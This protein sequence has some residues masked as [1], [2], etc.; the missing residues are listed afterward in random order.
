MLVWVRACGLVASLMCL[1]RV[2]GV[3]LGVLGEK[4][5]H[6]ILAQKQLLDYTHNLYDIDYTTNPT[7]LTH[8][9][10]SS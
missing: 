5:E 1:L 4:N 2:G 6:I 10:A 3:Y 8:N 9:H 7:K